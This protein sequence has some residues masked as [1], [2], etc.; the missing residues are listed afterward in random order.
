VSPGPN[1]PAAPK[2]RKSMTGAA[3]EAGSS[4]RK[5]S[6]SLATPGAGADAARKYCSMKLQE[7]F[8]DIFLRYPVLHDPAEEEAEEELVV[9][10][11]TED[12]TEEEKEKLEGKA[13]RFATELEECVFATY[14]EPDAKTGH[15]GVGMKYKERF[16][17]LTFN[18]SKADRVALHQR[19]AASHITP[20]EL[21]T[22]SSTDLANEET[23][24]SIR[25]AE[26]EALAHSILKKTS[27]PTAKMTHKGMQD[28]EDVSGTMSRERERERE[29]E[30]EERIERERLERVKLQARKAQAAQGSHPPESPITP[31]MPGWGAPPPVP[32]H[33]IQGNSPGPSSSS[34]PLPLHSP[35]FIHT[36]SETVSSPLEQELNLADLINIDEEPGEEFSVS[37]AESATASNLEASPIPA[38][39]TGG[40]DRAGSTSQSPPPPMSA[41][42]LSPFA[43]RSSHPEFTRRP[44]FDLNAIWTTSQ[45]QGDNAQDTPMQVEEEELLR[46]HRTASPDPAGDNGEGLADDQDFDMFLQG[47]EEE[48]TEEPASLPSNTPETIQAAF[49][50]A[51]YVWTGKISMPL[52]LSLSQEVAVTARQIGGRT[53]GG[54]SVLWKTLFPADHLRID[55]RVPVDKS[56]EYL[57]Q[58]RLNPHKELIAVAFAPEA[59]GIT[60]SFMT[61]SKYLIS[62]NRH[63][64][65]FPW[66]NRPKEHHPGR[67]L[68]IVP[69]VA[70]EPLPE[71]LELLDEVKLPQTRHTDYMVGIWVLN[72]GK[73][74]PPLQAV[75]PPPPPSAMSLPPVPLP[76]I[77]AVSTSAVPLQPP[78]PP[79][80][81]PLLPPAAALTSLIPPL[82]QL[83]PNVSAEA[84]AAEVASLTPEQI[85]LM[86]QTLAASNVHP[87]PAISPPLTLPPVTAAAAQSQPWVATNSPPPL[88]PYPP[89]GPPPPL[90]HPSAPPYTLPP[91]QDRYDFEHDRPMYPSYQ[92]GHPYD[93]YHDRGGY[94]GGRGSHGRNR[95]RGGG[96]ERQRDSG[97]RGRGRGRGR[98][99]HQSA[100][101]EGGKQ[102][103][104]SAQQ[105]QW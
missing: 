21:S 67:E 103:A 99:G 104:G 105:Q 100:A 34:R 73:L 24:Q 2:R 89:Y 5:R 90:G 84:L 11:K 68:Y 41:T 81:P 29:Q 56:A 88:P 86:L 19:I 33:A 26:K 83:P 27:M 9:M 82:S 96:Q 23:K 65:V 55:G 8:V 71:F 94:R 10:K 57:T 47:G 7:T 4:K 97:W 61:L 85:Q 30:E 12:L 46:G 87:A 28:I 60:D 92:A 40:D 17:M 77:S 1:S 45:E 102:W 59:H 15:H 39:S 38:E 79:P 63:G 49:D 98:G 6:E 78:P 62:K 69:L 91:S 16:R 44:S 50:A 75:P 18:L 35:P 42:G 3:H 36:S 70:S 64:L 25:Q 66:G 20:K 54:D 43:A 31:S 51:P 80:P 32:L 37:L 93:S 48:T 14:A 22:M 76:P 74:A 72:K 95:D 58:M 101:G 13:R 53:L 52:D